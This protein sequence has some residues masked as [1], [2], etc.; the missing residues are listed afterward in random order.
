ML[1]KYFGFFLYLCVFGS[2]SLSYLLNVSLLKE[3]MRVKYF[4]FHC[5]WC[6]L[7]SF[8]IMLQVIRLL[9]SVKLFWKL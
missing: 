2:L 1:L 5:G 4:E 7:S 9:P 8:P 6:W 3:P